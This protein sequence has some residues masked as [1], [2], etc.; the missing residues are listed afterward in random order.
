M[1]DSGKATLQEAFR[2]GRAVAAF[3]VYNL[4]GAKAVCQAAEIEGAPVMLQAGSSAFRYAGSDELASLALAVAKTSA[5]RVGVHLDHSRD[6]NEIKKCL[7][8]GYTSVMVDGSNLSFEDNVTLTRE[9]ARAARRAGAWIE[10]ELGGLGGDEDRSG[11]GGTGEITD[12]ESAAR[13]VEETGVDALA[14]AVGNVHGFTQHK[15]ELDLEQLAKIRKLVS[16]PLVLHGASGLPEHQLE[17]AIA[18]GVAKI[19]V[20]TELRRAF[21]AGVTDSVNCLE[22]DDDSITSLLAPAIER[23]RLVAQNKIR[24]LSRF[25]KVQKEVLHER[26]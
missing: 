25:E 4:E 26:Q 24:L 19:N 1:L 17:D 13:F 12:P 6:L 2:G 10:A 14:V 21:I 20:N 16:I 18:L 11:Q 8:F 22:Q 15:V 9:A 7:D 5:T 3:S 23:M